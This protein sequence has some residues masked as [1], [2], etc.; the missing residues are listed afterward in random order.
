[1]EDTYTGFIKGVGYT[2]PQYDAVEFPLDWSVPN[3]MW[4]NYL[5]HPLAIQ[6]I[7]TSP[8]AIFKSMNYSEQD[9]LDCIKGIMKIK[10]LRLLLEVIL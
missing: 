1:M 6:I 3:L 2:Y 5:P 4:Q 10:Q 8:E 9:I 7:D